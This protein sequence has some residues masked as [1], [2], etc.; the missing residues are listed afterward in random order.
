[1]DLL[2]L[3]LTVNHHLH[4]Y[5][6]LELHWP[7]SDATEPLPGEDLQKGHVSIGDHVISP[8]ERRMLFVY[9]SSRA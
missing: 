1:M 3:L 5:H 6:L 4:Y 9:T 7:R 8:I 2:P